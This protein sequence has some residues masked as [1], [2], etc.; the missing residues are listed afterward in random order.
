LFSNDTEIG[1]LMALSVPVR[2]SGRSGEKECGNSGP[3]GPLQVSRA[4]WMA[5]KH[6]IDREG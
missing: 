5:K 3:K 6:T 2:D 1:E 4:E